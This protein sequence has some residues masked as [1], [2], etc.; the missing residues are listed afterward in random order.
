MCINAAIFIKINNPYKKEIDH[1][2]IIFVESVN[3]VLIS[4]ISLDTHTGKNVIIWLITAGFVDLTQDPL[5]NKYSI[6]GF[7]RM[8]RWIDSVFMELFKNIMC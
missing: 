2:T 1:F 8:W 6:R 4:I 3:M 7:G 5:F